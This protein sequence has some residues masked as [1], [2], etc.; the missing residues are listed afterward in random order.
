[1]IRKLWSRSDRLYELRDV[2]AVEAARRVRPFDLDRG[3]PRH[4]WPLSRGTLQLLELAPTT[5][6]DKLDS[7]VVPV[8]HP[9]LEPETLCTPDEEIAEA[10]TLDIASDHAV[11][12]L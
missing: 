12:A 8:R 7:A 6:R 10:N 9:A 5:L 2:E 1:M 11:K 3:D 4:A